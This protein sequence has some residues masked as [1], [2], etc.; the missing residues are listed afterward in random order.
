MSSDHRETLRALFD[1]AVEAAH[2]DTCLPPHLP[3]PPAGRIIV[4]AAGKAA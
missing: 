4:L 2:P 1:A 3:E